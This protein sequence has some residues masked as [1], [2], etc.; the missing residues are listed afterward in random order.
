MSFFIKINI[1]SLYIIESMIDSKKYKLLKNKSGK[2]KVVKIY[3]V[4]KVIYVKV[5]TRTLYVMSKGKLMKLSK[6]KQMKKKVN[7]KKNTDKT[8]NVKRGESKRK[9]V[10]RRVSKK[11]KK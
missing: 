9:N 1:F 10:K 4:K 11:I 5:K 2:N 6:Y 3:G 7:S 8:K